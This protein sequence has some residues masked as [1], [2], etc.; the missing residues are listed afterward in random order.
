MSD[1]PLSDWTK[2]SLYMQENNRGQTP[3]HSSKSAKHTP[4]WRSQINRPC[5]ISLDPH[6]IYGHHIRHASQWLYKQPIIAVLPGKILLHPIAISATEWALSESGRLNEYME[7]RLCGV[8]KYSRSRTAFTTTLYLL[9]LVNKCFCLWESP[10]WM[11]VIYMDNSD[12]F[13]QRTR[14]S[15]FLL[16]KGGPAR[17]PQVITAY[18]TWWLN[19]NWVCPRLSY[20]RLSSLYQ[21]S[22][23]SFYDSDV[24]NYLSHTMAWMAHDILFQH[25]FKSNLT[26]HFIAKTSELE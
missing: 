1:R 12:W 15:Q 26:V 10:N 13:I 8:N 7:I 22:F 2:S 17:L 5:V 14:W 9:G 19:S 21:A 24:D 25:H 4:I 16:F 23:P 11:G 6:P 3:D 18:C 20:S